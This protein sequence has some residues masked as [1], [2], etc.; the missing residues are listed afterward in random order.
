MRFVLLILSFFVGLTFSN[1]QNHEKF[2]TYIIWKPNEKLVWSDFKAKPK[3]NG[4]ESAL[5]ASS[6]EL[7]YESSSEKKGFEIQVLCKFY[8]LM[9]WSVKSKQSDYILAHEQLHFDITELY[10]RKLRKALKEKI[11]KSSQTALA[12][13]IWQ[14]IMREWNLVQNQY[15]TETQHSLKEFKQKQWETKIQEELATLS[16]YASSSVFIP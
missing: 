16:D 8:P 15:D 13:K 2:E 9:S 1:A 14:D 12:N 5:T 11:T 3:P 4:Y 10:A 7:A 6:I